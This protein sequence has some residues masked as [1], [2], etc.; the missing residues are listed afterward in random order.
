[1]KVHPLHIG[2]FLKIKIKIPISGGIS[3]FLKLI[4]FGQILTKFGSFGLFWTDSAAMA[5]G[6]SMPS[7]E[8]KKRNHHNFC[9]KCQ[10]L[11]CNG[12]LESPLNFPSTK[13]VSK[14]PI[15]NWNHSCVP[16]IPKFH[17]W[18]SLSFRG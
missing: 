7:F 15:T 14:N 3:K 1:M 4:V 11:A 12:L 6:D 9:K 8:R 10:N 18:N 17:I 5:M 16:K 13:K 2:L